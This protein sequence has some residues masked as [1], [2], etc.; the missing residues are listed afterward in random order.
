M[1]YYNTRR[2]HYGYRLNGRTPAHALRDALGL[3]N[4]PSLD[5]S[6]ADSPSN[7]TIEEDAITTESA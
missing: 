3:D 4:L 6:L 2:T 5:F 1:T 7:P